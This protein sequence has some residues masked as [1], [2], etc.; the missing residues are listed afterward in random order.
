ML[1]SKSWLYSYILYNVRIRHRLDRHLEEIQPDSKDTSSNNSSIEL[2]SA[3]DEQFTMDSMKVEIYTIYIV[4]E[5][6]SLNALLMYP[7]WNV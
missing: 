5:W 4:S 1:R 7:Q 3:C 6:F 2:Q